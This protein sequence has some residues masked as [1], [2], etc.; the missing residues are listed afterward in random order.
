MPRSG[1][2]QRSNASTPI[3]ALVVE[4]VL[5]LEVQGELI[6]GLQRTTQVAE[7]GQARGVLTRSC[8]SKKTAPAL[9]SLAEYIAMSALREQLV[10]RRAVVR[11]QR[12]ADARLDVQ[13]RP[14]RGEAAMQRVTQSVGDELDVRAIL[15][16][17]QQ[18]G[19]LVAAQARQS[20]AMAKH[21]AQPQRDLTQQLVAVGVPER[22]VDLLE[23][24]EV[25]EQ[26]RELVVAARGEGERALDP[27]LEQHAVRQAGERV[28][29]GLAAEPA[30]G[31]RHDPIER[32]PDE[33]QPGAMTMYMVRVS[34]AIAVSVG[35]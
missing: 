30:R 21:L 5:R 14:A 3:E 9:C 35:V 11:R 8:G 2:C 23:A 17:R 20:V 4:G 33:Q 7:D 27:V 25:D 29:G 22:V 6:A 24:V 18:H 31:E 15:H 19:E 12:H 32:R 26:D 16:V 34:S 28:V 13:R 10:R 1:C